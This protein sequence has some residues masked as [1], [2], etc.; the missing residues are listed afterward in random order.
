MTTANYDK[1]HISPKK[2]QN[3][4]TWMQTDNII[5]NTSYTIDVHVLDPWPSPFNFIIRYG[6]TINVLIS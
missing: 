6:F 1:F 3:L 5:S 2:K 4:R